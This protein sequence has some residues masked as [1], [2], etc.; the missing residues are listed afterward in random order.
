MPSEIQQIL[1]RWD[2]SD[3]WIVI[4]A[5]LA[6]MACALPGTYLVL[7]R[8]SMV[9]DALTHTVL[10]GIVAA[11][12]FA[13]WLKSSGWIES[14]KNHATHTNAFDST[15][16]ALMFVGAIVTGI[17]TSLLTEWVQK[18]GRVESSA[19]IGVVYTTLFAIGLLM[20]RIAA[21]SVHIDPD[22]VL[23]GN[24][25]TVFVFT[26]PDTLAES[27]LIYRYLGDIQ[28]VHDIPRPA[29]VSGLC[30][31]VNGILLVLFFKELRI[32]AF[33][34]SLAT[35][36]GIN[37]HVMHYALMAVTAATA[38]A[39]F[40]SV[41]NIL[42]L[43]MLIV[44]PATAY[45]MTDKLTRLILIALIVAAMSAVLGHVSA[46][47]LPPLVF[48]RLG[49]DTVDDA[50]TS[51]M[52]AVA[53]GLLF[54][55]ALLFGPQHGIVSKLAQ[56]NLLSLRIACEDILGM[57]Y[58]LEEQDVTVGKISAHKLAKGSRGATLI[59]ATFAVCWLRLNRK[60]DIVDSS[61]CL[62]ELG[63]ESAK[64]LVRS[65]RLWESFLAKH[66]TLPNDHLHGSAERVE[67]FLDADVMDQLAAEL[68]TPDYDP[69]GRTIPTQNEANP[70]YS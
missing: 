9:G 16:Y 51:G 2:P 54:L 42:V 28:S 27:S 43:A 13:H 12:L 4:T 10:P 23:Y 3:T 60:V 11:F 18:L 22:C 19:A 33:D 66:F 21:D 69:H 36:L 41:G 15:S 49:F 53:S 59:W 38:V 62:T 57:L 24:I 64:R 56:N 70:D 45:L 63:R 52:M 17:L 8:Q 31:T 1:S 37:S 14:H 7:R 40:E 35:T 39:S 26:V 30:L 6:A 20:I 67:H 29:L 48:G 65:H 46:L 61:Y 55:L 32:S 34:P 68:D 50:S 47:T 44:P 25:E 5:A 58:R